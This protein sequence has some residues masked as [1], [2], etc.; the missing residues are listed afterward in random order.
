MDF[1]MDFKMEHLLL[2]VVA[3]F[4]LYHL[5]NGCGCANG[6]IDGFSVGGEVDGEVFCNPTKNNPQQFCPDGSSCPKCG[7]NS[8]KCPTP[9]PPG[10]TPEPPGPTPDPPGPTPEPPGPTPE[11]PGPTPEPPGPKPKCDYTDENEACY[12]L[13]N[14]YDNLNNIFDRFN[15]HILIEINYSDGSKKY[16]KFSEFGNVNNIIE[17]IQKL[18]NATPAGAAGTLNDTQTLF[19]MKLLEILLYLVIEGEASS[20]KRIEVKDPLPKILGGTNRRVGSNAID[21]VLILGLTPINNSNPLEFPGVFAGGGMLISGRLMIA[22]ESD[23]L[24]F[25]TIKYKD[26]T[27]KNNKPNGYNG[28]I[29][30][31]TSSKFP[32]NSDVNI[33]FYKKM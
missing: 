12:I 32:N 10:P 22:F 23:H 28:Y 6:V 2:F 14:K 31:R 3:A 24:I 15:K 20:R 17:Y 19:L 7:T 8:C 11:P 33:K 4:L 13:L 18:M 27:F 30:D 26:A 25:E 21:D 29:F 5:T 1:K 9:D 16:L